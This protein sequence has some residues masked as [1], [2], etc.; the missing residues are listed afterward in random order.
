LSEAI[1]GDSSVVGVQGEVD[2]SAN[3]TLPWR[4]NACMVFVSSACGTP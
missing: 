3:I 4:N 1:V 2:A